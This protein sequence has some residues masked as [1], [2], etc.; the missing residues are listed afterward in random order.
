M[1][2]LI[3]VLINRLVTKG[4]EI[5]TIPAYVRDLANTIAANGYS[6]LQE[7]NRRLK[8]LGWDDFEL[9]D[10]TLQLIIAGFEPD[11]A[12]KPPGWFDRNFNPRDPHEGS[13]EEKCAQALRIDDN[14]R[15]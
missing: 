5:T 6:S 13:D 2:D 12:Y 8:S 1:E 7:L 14:K 9:D 10:H 11:P 3:R 15:F 4:M